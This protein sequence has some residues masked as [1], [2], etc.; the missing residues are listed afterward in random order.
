MKIILVRHALTHFNEISLTQG[1][2][3]SPLSPKGKQQTIDMARQLQDFAIDKAYCSPTG[4]AKETLAILIKDRHIPYQ[5]E[6]RLKEIHF[7]IFEGLSI[8]IRNKMNIDSPTWFLDHNMDYRPYQ[9][10]F[11]SDVVARQEEF[12]KELTLKHANE[13]ILAVG[14]G[15]SLF[16]WLHAHF[17]DFYHH[18]PFIANSSAVVLTYEND[19][20][21][22]SQ[23][24]EVKDI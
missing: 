1:W 2:C 24:L 8:A 6:P 23:Y 9:G 19:H 3:D 13:T 16:A 20:W 15:C 14:H 17:P 12:F 4:R 18:I 21:H 10:E 11:I 22:F 7:G 5:E